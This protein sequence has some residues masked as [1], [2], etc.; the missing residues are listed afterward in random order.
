MEH[1]T[2]SILEMLT[3][4][5]KQYTKQLYDHVQA[6]G[7]TFKELIHNLHDRKPFGKAINFYMAAASK[8]V[9]Q[10][11]LL[12][13]PC[14]NPAYRKDV[15][16]P[17]Y[18]FKKHFCSEEDSYVNESDIKLCFVFNSMDNYTPFFQKDAAD[19]ICIGAPI[20]KTV[21]QTYKDLQGLAG[22]VPQ[23]ASINMGLKFLN[24]HLKAAHD[25]ACNMSFNA[26]FSCVSDTYM[27]SLPMVDP[28][29]PGTVRHCKSDRASSQDEPACKKTVTRHV[30]IPALSKMP[31]EQQSEQMTTESAAVD[32]LTNTHSY[33]EHKATDC[34]PNQCICGI[35]FP[36]FEA[37]QVHKGA[38][39]GNN[40]YHC[41]GYFQKKSGLERCTYETRDEGS[42]WRHY[43][44]I[45][46]G[47]FFH[48]CTHDDCKH[49]W[50]KN[51][52]G[53]DSLQNV[54][55]H[56]WEKHAVVSD[57]TCVNCGYVAGE[58]Y[59]FHRHMK[60]CENHD[61]SVKWL[62]CPDCPQKF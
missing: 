36:K 29:L 10:P 41:S 30:G 37:L 16:G 58:K 33:Y 24:I 26:G 52:Y 5:P 49:G 42:M 48:Y 7:K 12:V 46:C 40:A 43:R 15:P 27:Q 1:F 47:L 62:V 18:L 51:K 56:M 53:S 38:V 25:I 54:K 21:K 61:R 39:H 6:S 55:K 45:H 34:K 23:E 31:G 4:N 28:L 13:M 14:H 20:L 50:N 35:E 22:K 3:L 60:K 32:T 8:F 2:D 19:I 59:L 9:G 17:K 11:V 44:T 57:L